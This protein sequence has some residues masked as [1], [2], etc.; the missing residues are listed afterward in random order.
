MLAEPVGGEAL[1]DP[2]R[3]PGVAVDVLDEGA[4]V[5]DVGQAVAGTDVQGQLLVDVE[6][7][8]AGDEVAEEAPSEVAELG[9]GGVAA[10]CVLQVVEGAAEQRAAL[11]AD[12]FREGSSEGEGGELAEG[13]GLR[14]AL[15]LVA[16]PSAHLGDEA[17][18]GVGRPR[19]EAEV[20]QRVDEVRPPGGA[21]QA[22]QEPEA[23][24]EA[25][26]VPEPPEPG[27][28]PARGRRRDAVE[29][30]P[31]DRKE[32]DQVLPGLGLRQPAEADMTHRGFP[33]IKQNKSS[34]QRRAKDTPW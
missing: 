16:H 28:G 33:S 1:D 20:A 23:V 10:E 6:A 34:D 2:R 3:L 12:R 26:V 13:P 25:G 27:V 8:G 15:D 5:L 22:C 18:R 19:L 24:A 11:R 14:V 17:H 9:R 31:R 32:A 4:A 7:E 29:V 21:R 30:R